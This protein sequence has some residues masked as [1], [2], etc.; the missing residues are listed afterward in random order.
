VNKAF[1]NKQEKD[2]ITDRENDNQNIGLAQVVQVIGEQ[3]V[4]TFIVLFA[5]ERIITPCIQKP[6]HNK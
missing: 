6:A 1:F 2:R 4:Q 5:P 3:A